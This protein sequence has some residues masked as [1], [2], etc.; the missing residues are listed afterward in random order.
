MVEEIKPVSPSRK[1]KNI[2]RFL[3]A[4]GIILLLNILLAN[5]YFRIDLTED[6]RYTIA[7][8]TKQLLANLKDDITVDVYLAGDFPARFKRLQS[9]VRET[10]DES[11]VYSDERVQFNFIDPSGNTN[12]EKRNAY[13]QQLVA[14]GL[15]PT[16]LVSAEGDKKVEKL[17]F[18]GGIV[19]EGQS[20]GLT[21]RTV[22][23]IHRRSG[24]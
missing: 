13:Y 7:P 21:R 20:G 15:Q 18:P 17:I 16:N 24:I 11:R 3:V 4:L 5:Q 23:S 22:K 14:K 8:V 19:S 10:L 6:K 9:S 2:T 1:K 12:P